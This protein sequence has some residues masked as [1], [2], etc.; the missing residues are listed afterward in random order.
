MFQ[1]YTRELT[2]NERW[3]LFRQKHAGE[4][5]DQNNY[6]HPCDVVGEAT[7]QG[8]AHEFLVQ[9]VVV[10]GTGGA[11][12]SLNHETGRFVLCRV[13]QCKAIDDDSFYAEVERFV[14][15]LETWT[16]VIG[17]FR[18][19]PP[20]DDKAMEASSDVSGFIAV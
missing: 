7:A 14:S 9:L 17:N 3:E 10:G 20:S 11:T 1:F 5:Y 15:S 2:R 4:P 18:D 13:L 6:S 12:L 8:E 19:S 16:K